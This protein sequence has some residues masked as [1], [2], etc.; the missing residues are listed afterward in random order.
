[1]GGPK[2][3]HSQSSK[4]QEKQQ[5]QVQTAPLAAKFEDCQQWFDKLCI[6]LK[7]HPSLCNLDLAEE[8][9]AKFRAWGNDT[10]AVSRSLDHTL[11]KASAHQKKTLELLTTLHSTLL[12]SMHLFFLKILRRIYFNA[13]IYGRNSN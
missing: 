11:R 8:S 1:M 7:E 6:A 12:E 13:N 5:R 3:Y 2:I 4:A 9:L 10:G